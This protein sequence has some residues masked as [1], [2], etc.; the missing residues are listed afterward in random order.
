METSFP[1]FA[2]MARR[3]S[4]FAT[5]PA[6]LAAIAFPIALPLTQLLVVLPSALSSGAAFPLVPLPVLALFPVLSLLLGLRVTSGVDGGSRAILLVTGFI[7]SIAALAGAFFLW[8]AAA[9]VGCGD[10]YECPF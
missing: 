3:V 2:R 6:F 8:L 7:V 10:R 5:S 9:E 4:D 1:T